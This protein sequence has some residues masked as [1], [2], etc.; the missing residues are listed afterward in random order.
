MS[1]KIVIPIMPVSTR[2]TSR[3]GSGVAGHTGETVMEVPIARDNVFE[4]EASGV[5]DPRSEI[6][7]RATGDDNS[8]Q[9]RADLQD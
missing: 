8:S 7:Q 4:V 3:D 1:V 9:Y 6:S 5:P 2:S